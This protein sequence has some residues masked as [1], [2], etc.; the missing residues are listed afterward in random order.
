MAGRVVPL[1]LGIDVA[2]WACPVEGL[3]PGARACLWVRGC[4]RRPRCPECVSSE[5]WA[6]GIR[7]PVRDVAEQLR[8]P[9]GVAAGLTI[10]GG[11]PFDQAREVLQLVRAVRSLAGDIEV[12]VYSGYLLEELTAAGGPARRLLT[13]IDMLVDGPY[14]VTS[15]DRLRWRGSDN[16]R[17]HL[18]SARA[19]RHRAESDQPWVEPRP[20][21]IQDLGGGD[22]RIVGIPRRGEAARLRP[23]QPQSKPGGPEEEE[24]WRRR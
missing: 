3:G 23:T 18:L 17:V 10:S 5:L 1:P 20:L 19:G 7:T 12:L 21:R 8:V 16:Q 6:P 22:Y 4:S 14:L 15:G 2:G 24:P 11:E 9:L 13:E